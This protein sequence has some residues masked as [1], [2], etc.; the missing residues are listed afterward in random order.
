MR[1]SSIVGEDEDCVISSQLFWG[2]AS[3][4]SGDAAVA[5]TTEFPG[6]TLLVF[7]ALYEEAPL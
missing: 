4:W 5:V 6:K 2:Q 7:C 3:M 1:G